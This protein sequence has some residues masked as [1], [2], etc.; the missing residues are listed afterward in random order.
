MHTPCVIALALALATVSAAAQDKPVLAPPGQGPSGPQE[1][2][3]APGK[4]QDEGVEK[5]RAAAKSADPEDEEQLD[6]ARA[7]AR[8]ADPRPDLDR[9]RDAARAADPGGKDCMSARDAR[10]AIAQKR[11]VSLSQ[12]L[13][14]A[15]GAWDGEVIDYKLCTFDGALAY[16]LTL[17][18]D[19]GR[20]ARVRVEAV[21]GKL[22][23][24]R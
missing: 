4:P 23:G 6:R 2:A 18:N 15:R 8:A 22:V 5:A 16:D 24:V 9:A 21:S 12:A 13:R 3:G 19:D 17:L 20:V 10:G 1:P 11:A 14:T 7:A